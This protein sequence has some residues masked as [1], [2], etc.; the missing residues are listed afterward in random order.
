MGS[1]MKNLSMNGDAV[2]LRERAEHILRK[3]KQQYPATPNTDADLRKQLHE[4]QINQIELEMQNSALIELH[5]ARMETEL[6]LKRY[7]DLYDLA[8]I[9][10]FTLDRAGL[11]C[12]ANLTA[13]VL[14]RVERRQLPGQDFNAYIS[15]DL[16]SDF[17][18][19]LGRVFAH[20]IRASCELVLSNS[21]HQPIF[22]HMDAVPDES[23]QTC[24]AIVENITLRKLAEKSLFNA[25]DQLERSVHER[26][27]ELTDINE[28][29]RVEVAERKRTEAALLES[30]AALRRLGAYQERIKEDERKRIAREIHDELGSLLTGIRANA[31]VA[32]GNAERGDRPLEQLAD[33]AKLADLAID[34][35]RK[36]I[37]ELRPSV[38]DQLGV[39]A[40]LEWYAGQVERRT[41]LACECVLDPHAVDTELDPERSTALFRIVQE[42]LTNAARHAMASRVTISVTRDANQ[43]K[44]EVQ[45]DG[46]G[47]S[48]ERRFSSDSWGIAGMYERALHFDGEFRICSTLGR[49]T[50][51]FFRF[52]LEKSHAP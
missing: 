35:V 24:R 12:E 51:V 29:L 18:A 23:G 26:T 22:V 8:P 40:A 1:D 41:G 11:I 20:K 47:I 6:A 13:A 42:A 21:R 39:W 15:P 28:A 10:Y 46:K 50:L 7:A 30:R 4:L 27:A 14:L 17:K 34:T 36:V 52:P 2:A 9:G 33:I 44:V 19:F 25:H 32:L 48:D 31:C 37:T 49:G 45:D 16:Q 3:R 5:E 38:L 43:I